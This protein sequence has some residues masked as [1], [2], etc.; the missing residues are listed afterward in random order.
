MMAVSVLSSHTC[1]LRLKGLP[2]GSVQTIQVLLD[3]FVLNLLLQLLLLL[4]LVLLLLVLLPCD[5]L[6]LEEL[7]FEQ[8]AL[9]LFFA[10]DSLEFALLLDCSQDIRWFGWVDFG[11]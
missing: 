6:L 4:E 2:L 11:Q 9:I 3:K 5:L 8:L 7:L 1:L 10:K